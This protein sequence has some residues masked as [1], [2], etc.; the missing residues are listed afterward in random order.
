VL[1][2][3]LVVLLLVGGLGILAAA[4]AGFLVAQTALAPVARFTRRAES[5]T[6]NPDLSERL[7]VTGNDE[8]A[9]LARS[10]N[11]TLAALESSVEAQ[12]HLVADASHELRTPIASLRANI[13]VLEDANRRPARERAALRADIVSELD[14]LTTLVGDV[15]DLARGAKQ[16]DVLDDVRLDSVVREIAD[17]ARRRPGAPSIDLDLEPTIVTG[18]PD[19]IT[20]IVS[21]LIDNARKWSPEGDVV[22]VRLRGGELT[23]RDH[24]PGFREEDLPHVFERFFRSDEARA[25]PG[26]GLGL[27]IVKQGAE[28]TGGSVEAANAPDGGA[29]V[30]VRFGRAE[31]LALAD[32]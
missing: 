25:L 21:N 5:L 15:V 22:D 17:R 14:E 1:H 30:R 23:V 2:R 7:E 32:L 27:A 3:Q 29:I 9:R 24:G 18:E 28:A 31:R 4:G 13:Q 19:R 11:T 8:I 12:R 6:A 16:A 20:R 10:F 26:S